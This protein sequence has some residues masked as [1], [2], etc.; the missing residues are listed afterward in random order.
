MIAID[1]NIIVY[2]HRRDS[3]L[4]RN[5]RATL[6]ALASGAEKWAIPWPCFH[7]FYAVVT[8]SRA[9]APPSTALEAF[10]QIAPILESPS[11]VLLAETG[12]HWQVLSEI[13]EY[14]GFRN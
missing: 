3:V 14:P 10:D 6:D 11:L 4:H 9:Y 5:A 2:A 8:N 13:L 12:R 7:E 1:T